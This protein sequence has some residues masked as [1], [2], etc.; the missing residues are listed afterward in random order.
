MYAWEINIQKLVFQNK[1]KIDARKKCVAPN[2][3][4]EET[5]VK[6]NTAIL[7]IC[8]EKNIMVYYGS[9]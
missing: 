1:N 5:Q 7:R 8:K 2:L 4:R 9:Q 3:L 6:S